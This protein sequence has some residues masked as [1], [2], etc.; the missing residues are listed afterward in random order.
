MEA[1]ANFCS[2]KGREKFS[3]FKYDRLGKCELLYQYDVSI[4]NDSLI[5]QFDQFVSYKSIVQK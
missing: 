2:S 3:L 4:S 5:V 1:M